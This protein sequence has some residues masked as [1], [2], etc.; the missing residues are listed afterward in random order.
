MWYCLGLRESVGHVGESHPNFG[1]A[2][3][4]AEF[5]SCPENQISKVPHDV[6]LS[7]VAGLPLA[8]LT[9]YQALFT[10]H[11]LSTQGESLGDIR[12]GDKVLI[13]GG[14]RGPGHLALQ[15][16]VHEGATVT[17]TVPKNCVKWATVAGASR[18]IDFHE[19]QWVD[20]LQ[21]EGFNWVF[22]FVGWASR[23]TEMDIAA[24]VLTPGGTYVSDSHLETFSAL[25]FANVRR[26]R[27][28]KAFVPTVNAAD[29][30]TLVGWVDTYRL[31]VEIDEVCRFAS[32]RHALLESVAG[33]CRGKV[34][35]CQRDPSI[36]A[37]AAE[38]RPPLAATG[39]A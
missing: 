1:P 25:G 38:P 13:L 2:G 6:L 4:F 17:T 35:L 9:A 16:A 18:V 12:K 27:F 28:F 22:D 29:L 5:C 37:S 15:M 30:D 31:R 20:E 39:G 11:G 3:A 33:H 34:L 7:E 8:G 32:L 23:T 24:G 36:E 10:G 21:G 26:G 14:N 19:T